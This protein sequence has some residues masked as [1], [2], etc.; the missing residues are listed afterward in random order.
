LAAAEEK[1]APQDPAFAE[2][3]LVIACKAI[4]PENLL[5][6]KGLALLLPFGDE[7]V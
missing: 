6:G 5:E 3:R 1:R 7:E 2:V 4:L